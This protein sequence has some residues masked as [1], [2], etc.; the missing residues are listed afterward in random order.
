MT[1]PKMSA[2]Q[3]KRRYTKYAMAGSLALL[4]VSGFGKGKSSRNLH[5]AAG[6]ALIG[7]SVYHTSLY[8][9]RS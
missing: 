7:L 6:A 2:T 8:K 4:L 1:A 5:T 3:K 9:N